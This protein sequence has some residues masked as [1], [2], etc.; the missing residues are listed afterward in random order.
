MTDIIMY[1]ELPERSMDSYL[2]IQAEMK[3]R[4]YTVKFSNNFWTD[5]WKNL[6]RVPQ[7]VLTS[8]CRNLADISF[9]DSYILKKDVVWVNLQEEQ[10]AYAGG[11]D[12]DS[13]KPVDRAKE[14]YHFCWGQFAKNYMEE[15]GVEKDHIIDMPPLQFDL[16]KPRF[17]GLYKSREAIAE[18]YGINPDKKW[19][20]FASDFCEYA[21]FNTEQLLQKHVDE[22]GE[23]RRIVYNLEK[24]T[25]LMMTEWW[26]K[27]LSENE[28]YVII[29]RPHP[30]EYCIIPQIGELAEKY[31]NFFIIKDYSIKQWNHVVEIYT[32]WISTSV[33]EAYYSGIPVF[34]LAANESISNKDYNISIFDENKYIKD[35]NTFKKIL[36]EPEKYRDVYNPLNSSEIEKYYGN[37]KDEYAYLKICD[38]LEQILKDKKLYRKMKMHLSYREKNSCVYRNHY[39][40]I[41][42]KNDLIVFLS[43]VLLKLFPGKRKTIQTVINTLKRFDKRLYS[44]HKTVIDEIV[45]EG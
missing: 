30:S 38:Y 3:K 36:E 9:Q 41:T 17:S 8:G 11:G 2:L 4:G 39:M 33:L 24:A 1:Y 23:T 42:F 28:D 14:A 26:D 34:A 29:Y 10:V 18:E 12:L 22:R 45:N 21:N 32:T 5:L 20:L 25:C 13:F 19:I 6:F 35:Y 43:P 44:S 31:E 40:K 15:A 7:I 16:A 37:H 27:L